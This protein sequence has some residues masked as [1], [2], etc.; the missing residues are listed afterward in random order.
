MDKTDVDGYFYHNTL[1]ISQSHHRLVL[2]SKGSIKKPFAFKIFHFC[3][4]KLQQQFILMKKVS[5][6]KKGIESLLGSSGKF[7]KAFDQANKVL[8]IPLA[9]PKFEIGFTKAK[10]ELINHCHKDIVEP[11]NRQIRL[12]FRFEKT[13]RLVSFPAKSLNNTVMNSFLQKLST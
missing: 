13:T 1:D 9:K 5:I 7:Q 12:S 11:L 8:Q 3:D 4:S 2:V 6:S 10:D